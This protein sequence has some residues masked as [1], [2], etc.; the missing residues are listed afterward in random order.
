MTQAERMATDRRRKAILSLLFFAPGQTLTARALRD[1]L[2]E[3]HGQIAT[4]DKVRA[5]LAWLADV[6]FIARVEDAATL[7]ETGREIVLGRREMS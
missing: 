6:E 2:E 1:D 4:V 5:D 3:T 7:T